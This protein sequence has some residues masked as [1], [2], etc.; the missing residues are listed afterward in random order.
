MFKGW[1]FHPAKVPQVN[2]HYLYSFTDEVAVK[3]EWQN[4]KLLAQTL[5]LSGSAK[6]MN[7]QGMLTNLRFAPDGKLKTN[8]KYS[9]SRF[10]EYMTPY[11]LMHIS[12]SSINADVA[13]TRDNINNGGFTGWIFQPPTKV[14]LKNGEYVFYIGNGRRVRQKWQNYRLR[15]Q[16]VYSRRRPMRLKNQGGM[17]ATMLFNSEG[18]CSNLKMSISEMCTKSTPCYLSHVKTVDITYSLNGIKKTPIIRK[19]IPEHF[20]TTK[21]TTKSTLFNPNAKPFTPG[22]DSILLRVSKLR[23]EFRDGRNVF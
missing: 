4:E 5:M 10:C 19:Q 14:V 6:S 1:I 21:S 22:L 13:E 8:H 9:I 11:C 18:W 15:E 12:V 23:L 16:I 2:G 17:R 7:L 20:Q 3:Q